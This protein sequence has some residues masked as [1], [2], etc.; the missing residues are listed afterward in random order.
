VRP[1]SNSPALTNERS[2]RGS[3]LQGINPANLDDNKL[4]WVLVAP[5]LILIICVFVYPLLYSLWMS[6]HAYDI[7]SPAR[8]VGFR[9]YER[10]LSDARFWNSVRVSFSF[11]IP[12]FILE[13]IT[14]FG[15]ALLINRDIR[16]KG[17]IRSVI[18]MPLMLTPVVVG[19]NWRVMFNYDFGIINWMF[20]LIGI[21]PLNFVNDA[22][23]AL[24]SLVVLEMWRSTAF[25]MLVMSAGLAAL[26]EEPFQ[27]ADIDGASSW[28][29]LIF[30]TMP[31]LKPLFLVIAIFRSYELLRVFDI[32]YTLT[33]GG[34]G[35][36]TETLSFH[37]FNRLFE[38]WQV[39]YASAVSYMLFLISLVVVLLV[40]KVL[41]LGGFERED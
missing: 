16:G 12:T 24:P 37:V 15:L 1:Q 11:A 14:G 26:P 31:M 20:G 41:G 33:G 25:V 36:A 6:F 10:I 23:L 8:F 35:R 7:I 38:G 5:A 32:V 19:L 28:Q 2:A 39:G 17:L 18:L 27:A 40:V 9:N 34:P 22:Q 21:G 29:K 13:L 3:L 30:L 4:R